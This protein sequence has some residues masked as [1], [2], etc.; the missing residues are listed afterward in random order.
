MRSQSELMIEKQAE[1]IG[2]LHAQLKTLSNQRDKLLFE[3]DQ[4]K[5]PAA[6]YMEL[7]HAVLKDA[8]LQREWDRF[9]ILLKLKDADISGK[10]TA[11]KY[12]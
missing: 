4:L 9:L 7:Q 12:I 1:I 8:D 11:E 10:S 2:R 3:I 6:Y 5:K